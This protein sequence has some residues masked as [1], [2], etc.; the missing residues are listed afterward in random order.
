MAELY[1]LTEHSDFMMSFVFITDKNRA[2]I[3]D[4]GRPSDMEHLF[5]IVEKRRN[6]H[7]GVG[8]EMR[9]SVW[10]SKGKKTIGR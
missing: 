5:E 7:W 8:I 10:Y 9:P 2:I 4:G 1:M 6:L 3:I